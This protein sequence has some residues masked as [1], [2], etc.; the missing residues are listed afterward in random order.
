MGKLN[1]EDLQKIKDRVQ[2]TGGMRSKEDKD[3]KVVVHM[4]T[5]GIASG[6]RK[7]MSE[8]LK[9]VEDKNLD[10]EIGQSGCIGICDR[11]PI[12]SVIRKNEP[13]VRYGKV[14]P[15][16]IAEIVE[17]HVIG[18]KVIDK[19]VLSHLPDNKAEGE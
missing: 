1:I 3:I 8:L 17:S 4:G 14:T 9:I 15:E 11:E 13:Q 19:Y 5:C 6:A 16:S 12:V 10:I 18:G 7:V 2:V